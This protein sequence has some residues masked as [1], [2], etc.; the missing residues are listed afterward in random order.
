LGGYKF[1]RQH[2]IEEYFVDFVCLKKKLVIE[3][4]GESHEEQIV[5]DRIRQADLERLGFTVL[6]YTE[7]DVVENL[8][9]VFYSICMFL[10]VPYIG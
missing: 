1:R 4:D 9:G 8:E 2:S 10:G 3:I 5:Y 6:R 7:D